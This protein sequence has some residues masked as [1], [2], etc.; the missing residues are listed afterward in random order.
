MFL[1]PADLVFPLFFLAILIGSTV[2]ASSWSRPAE[3]TM[4]ASVFRS[5][6]IAGAEMS[7]IV[8]CAGCAVL[9][10]AAGPSLLVILGAT[11][12]PA[13]RRYTAR[14]RAKKDDGYPH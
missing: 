7:A 4:S 6:L 10:G 8:A 1:V 5:A 14:W 12:P 9:L 13:M 11:S 2:A 3:T